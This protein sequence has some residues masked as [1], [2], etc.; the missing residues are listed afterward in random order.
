METFLY[1][2]LDL[3]RF[4]FLYCTKFTIKNCQML[5]DYVISF[6]CKINTLSTYLRFTQFYYYFEVWSQINIDNNY[7]FINL[8]YTYFLIVF[9]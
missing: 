5:P 6:N 2:K 4:V 1:V 9:V 8:I 7:I 3:Y